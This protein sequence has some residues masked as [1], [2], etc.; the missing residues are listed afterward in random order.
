MSDALNLNLPRKEAASCTYKPEGKYLRFLTIKFWAPGKKYP[1]THILNMPIGQAFTEDGV[2]ETLEDFGNQIEVKYPSHE[3]CIVEVGRGA[4]N[5]LCAGLKDEWKPISKSE[6]LKRD[7]AGIVEKIS[8]EVPGM[9]PTRLSDVFATAISGTA[10]LLVMFFAGELVPHATYRQHGPAQLNDL[11][12]TPGAVGTMTTAQLCD[13]SFH[14]GTV[15]SVT[16]QTKRIACQEYGIAPADCNGRNVEIDHLI[17][18]E[19]GGSND[20]AN[21]W[22]QPYAPRPGAKEKDVVENWLHAQVCT[23]HLQLADAQHQIAT[24]WYAI[25]LTVPKANGGGAQ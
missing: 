19:L 5:F 23:N 12:V 6:Q 24:D 9:I 7:V 3:F 2:Q 20:L 10:L 14:T 25:F 21:L 8:A 1:R 4:F 11:V 13:K 18:L 17:S 15:R 16:E 22:P